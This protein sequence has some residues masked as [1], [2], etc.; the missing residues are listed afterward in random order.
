MTVALLKGL[1]IFT[2]LMIGIYIYSFVVREIINDIK[3]R[4]EWNEIR[5]IRQMIIY[6]N[7]SWEE[8]VLDE[9]NNTIECFEAIVDDAL[10][11]G[12]EFKVDNGK[13]YFREREVEK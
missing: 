5:D 4:K 11:Y 6:E 1:V 3:D 7:K 8:L 10:C 2:L 9:P 12:F 13:I